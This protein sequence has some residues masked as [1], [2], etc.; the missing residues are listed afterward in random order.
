LGLAGDLALGNLEA[1]RD[2]GFAGDVVRAMWMMLQAPAAGDYVVATG[3]TH[4]VREF[5]DAAFGH[6]GLDYRDYVREDSAFYRP[7]EP[8]QL[9]GNSLKLHSLGWSPQ[10]D[11][12]QLVGMMVDEDMRVLGGSSQS[13][14]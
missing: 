2:W 1:R 9:V 8:V 13:A 5:C 11:F 7:L 6:L 14:T 12:H 10:V 4:S 3:K